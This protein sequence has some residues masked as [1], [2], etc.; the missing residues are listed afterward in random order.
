MFSVEFKKLKEEHMKKFPKQINL[1]GVMTYP[2][3]LR[4]PYWKKIQE[5]L[6]ERGGGRCEACKKV[7][8]KSPHHITYKNIYHERT[9]D[10]LA[11]CATCHSWLHQKGKFNP[12]Y[13]KE[14]G[15]LMDQIS[16]CK[17]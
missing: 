12:F 17:E 8:F 5:I 6:F 16:S 11:V 2:K 1:S 14:D 15:R 4:S 7:P 9:R 13:T 10:V 3:H